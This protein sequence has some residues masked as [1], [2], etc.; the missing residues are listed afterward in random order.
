MS[1]NRTN[2]TPIKNNTQDKNPAYVFILNFILSFCFS[3]R[4]TA[5]NK[6]DYL[7]NR[8]YKSAERYCYSV[9]GNAYARKSERI[10]KERYLAYGC[11]CDKCKDSIADKEL[12]SPLSEKRLPL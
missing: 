3:L 1:I 2:A 9:F 12:L 5:L 11:R 7:Y 6:L 10:G 4:G 8:N